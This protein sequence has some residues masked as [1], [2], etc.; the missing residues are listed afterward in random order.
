MLLP[1]KYASRTVSSVSGLVYP[2][3]TDEAKEHA[4]SVAGKDQEHIW[5]LPTM[6]SNPKRILK[7]RKAPEAHGK[8][9]S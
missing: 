9:R 8:K 2:A 3:L 7:P 6:L 5:I 4:S 1:K